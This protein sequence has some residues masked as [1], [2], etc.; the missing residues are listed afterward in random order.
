MTKGVHH[1][2][3]IWERLEAVAKSFAVLYMHPITAAA[4]HAVTHLPALPAGQTAD[5]A[6]GFTDA[7][8]RK[9]NG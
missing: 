5:V 4:L 6:V 3:T 1:S 2:K 8:R 9:G 7:I